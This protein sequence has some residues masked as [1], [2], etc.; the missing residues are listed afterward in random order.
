ML[1]GIEYSFDAL[2]VAKY[3]VS[4]YWINMQVFVFNIVNQRFNVSR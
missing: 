3:E 4:Y 2:D 1:Y